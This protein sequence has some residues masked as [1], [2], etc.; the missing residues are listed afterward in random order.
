MPPLTRRHFLLG[1]T[2][3]AALGASGI[4]LN[5]SR[6]AAGRQAA[7]EALSSTVTRPQD[8]RELGRLYLEGNAT[9]TRIPH[10]DTLI[11]PDLG[12]FAWQVSTDRAREAFSTRVAADFEQHDVVE[13]D[14]WRYAR[15]EARFAARY[16]LS[17]EDPK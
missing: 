12:P 10:L 6:L 7:F 4:G 1:G 5:L 13:L 17:T 16:F 3:A 15:S 8:L 9:E 14:G 2:A 11:F